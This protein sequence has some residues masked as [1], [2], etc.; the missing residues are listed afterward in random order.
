[1]PIPKKVIQH[2]ENLAAMTNEKR[3]IILM[4]VY[5]SSFLKIGKSL[6]FTQIKE[7]T[8]FEKNDLS[9]HIKL[10]K[11]ARLIVKKKD[12]HYSVTSTGIELIKEMG[13]SD[14]KIKELV[15]EIKS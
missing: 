10:L 5:N 8:K 14:S 9:Y 2:L 1:M 7:V 11:E 4:S 15:K 3:F 6:T 13:F 12:N